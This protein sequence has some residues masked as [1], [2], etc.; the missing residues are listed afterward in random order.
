MTKSTEEKMRNLEDV[1]ETISDD[2]KTLKDKRFNE[3]MTR[4]KFV[5]VLF[6]PE[7]YK[8]GEDKVNDALGDGF[9]VMRDFETGGGIVMCLAKWE[10]KTKEVEK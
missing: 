7:K 1:L 5:G 3:K 4:M 6:D 2:I 8:D 9:E 10:K